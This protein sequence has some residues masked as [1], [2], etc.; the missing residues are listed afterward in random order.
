MQVYMLILEEQEVEGMIWNHLLIHLCFFFV[1][2]YHG[3]DSRLTF[4]FLTFLFW[5][6]SCYSSYMVVCFI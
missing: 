4:D 6:V 5:K 2:D 1:V 3:K